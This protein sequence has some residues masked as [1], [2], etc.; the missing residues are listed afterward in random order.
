VSREIGGL[1]RGRGDRP[2]RQFAA[3]GPA[4]EAAVAA[5]VAV[6]TT[7]YLRRGADAQPVEKPAARHAPKY[8]N[9]LAMTALADGLRVYRG[10]DSAYAHQQR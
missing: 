7:K 9:V 8:C 10:Y 3:R 5:R 6:L 1:A 2:V 4:A